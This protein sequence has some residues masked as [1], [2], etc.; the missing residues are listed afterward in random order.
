VNRTLK[1]LVA[2]IL[3][4]AT[5]AACSGDR[6][7]PLEADTDTSTVFGDADLTASWTAYN[8]CVSSGAGNAPNVTQFSTTNPTGTLLKYGDGT[9]TTVA[10]SMEWDNLAPWNSFG[11]PNPGTD[12]GTTFGGIVNLDENASY[13]SSSA[14]WYYQVTFSGLD[15]AR[16]YAFVATANRDEVLYIGGGTGSRWT[17]FSIIGADTYE[18]VSSSGVIEVTGAEL[19]MN[20]GYNTEDGLVIAWTDTS[21]ASGTF[22]VRSQNVGAAG[23]GEP[24]KS[25]G[26][27]GFMFLE[28]AP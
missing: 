15:P 6:S 21:S 22:T 2:A 8:D 18:N 7:D 28:L 11:A 5:V 26:M 27:Q 10:V 4:A 20:T 25:Y 19:K 1:W 24:Y 3:I 13:G 14:D 9:A 16:E 12:A 23:P 17:K